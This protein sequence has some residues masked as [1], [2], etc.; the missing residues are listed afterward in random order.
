MIQILESQKLKKVLLFAILFVA[1]FI[2]VRP[3]YP[4]LRYEVHSLVGQDGV[5]DVQHSDPEAH[6]ILATADYTLIGTA[7]EKLAMLDNNVNGAALLQGIDWNSTLQL[8]PSDEFQTEYDGRLIISKIGV[9]MPIVMGNDSEEG[10]RLGAWL[11]P[12]TSTP[13]KRSNTVLAGHRFQYLPPSSKTLYLLDKVSVGD[14]IIVHWRGREYTYLMTSSKVVPPSQVDV[15][16]G[17]D[18]PTITLITCTPV[19]S[20]KER[21]IVIGE[22]V[23]IR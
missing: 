14:T 3:F 21:L 8:P 20:D 5:A 9:D 2:L 16:N 6:I 7:E 12:G 13:D 15:L 23:D 19:F 18:K 4:S 10:L 17:T 11:I 22:L 1:V